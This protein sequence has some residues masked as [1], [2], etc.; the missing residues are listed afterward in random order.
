M[1]ILQETPTDIQGGFN[2]GIEGSAMGLMMDILQRFQY[3]YPI[4]STIRE[5]VSN[6]IDSVTEKN[7]AA[8]ILSGKA[9]ITDYYE[10][11]EG[12]LYNDSKFD[13]SYYDA[14]YFSSNDKVVV[15][16]HCGDNMDKDFVTIEDHGVGLGGHRLSKYFSLG[17]ST[18]RLSKL[19]LG[20]F[21]I[22]AKAP[23]SVNPYYT[24]ESRYNGLRYKFNVYNTKVESVIPKFNLN[25]GVE[26]VP[27]NF[28]TGVIYAEKTTEKNGVIVTMEAKKHH[29]QEYKDAVE[30][31]LMYFTNVDF[32]VKENGQSIRQNFT[33]EILYEDDCLVI[34]DN[35]YFNKPHMLLN[36]VNY[37]FIDFKELELEDMLG[38]VGIKVLPEDVE[39]SPSR[40]SLVWSEKTKAMV[41]QRFKDASESASRIIQKEMQENDFIK[42]LRVCN[43]IKNKWSNSSNIL[44][45]LSNIVNLDKVDINFT[46]DP[47]IKYHTKMLSSFL[48]REVFYSHITKANKSGKK[49]ERLET[50]TTHLNDIVILKSSR[51]SNRKDKYLLSL[52]GRFTTLEKPEWMNSLLIL[53]DLEENKALQKRHDLEDKIYKHLLSSK[54]ILIYEDIEV[55]EDFL[56]SEED[57]DITDLENM[58]AEELA[59][60]NLT[61][62]ERRKLNGSTIVHTPRLK[63]SSLIGHQDRVYEW[64]KVEVPVKEIDTWDEEE[65]Y[66]GTDI[67]A[68]TL[69]FVALL[70]RD[71]RTESI[72]YPRDRQIV[73]YYNYRRD[74]DKDDY[75]DFKGRYNIYSHAEAYRCAHFFDPH[76][77]RI[78]KVA[79]DKVKL[80]QD[81]KHINKFF[82]KVNGHTITMS[83]KLIRWNTSRL[84][85]EQLNKL[86]FLQNFPLDIEQ[87]EKYNTLTKY[88]ITNYVDMK[89]DNV[90]MKNNSQAYTDMLSHLDKVQQFQMLV[91][92]EATAEEI[93]IV[94]KEM[95]GSAEIQDGC[96]VDLDILNILNELLDWSKPVRDL[97]NG[98]EYLL[99]H[100]DYTEAFN[101]YRTPYKWTI[102][103]N[104]EESI[105]RYCQEKNVI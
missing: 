36:K 53:E 79:K 23:L 54:E 72:G 60:I 46:G 52:H 83:N 9:Q 51:A 42:W 75:I 64:Q 6:G 15:T 74:S 27:I 102:P 37:G 17:Y 7:V 39:I 81:F 105:I 43:S 56:A 55:P 103:N 14:T 86:N 22:G 94:A 91:K 97:L 76:G 96:A 85:K 19:P 92:S 32:Y 40:E 95:W 61:N 71:N 88:V 49:V 47:S 57:E 24:M 34:S 8:L 41:L 68:Q 62:E 50:E 21:G 104:M 65:I 48:N 98:I 80:Y 2:K 35:R 82:L 11:I 20:K 26:N 4:K 100:S 99:G 77:I 89:I 67:D 58:T 1:A 63:N 13:P 78:I 70:T 18:K 87:K 29:L 84:V 101:Q 33:P 16:Y 5:L 93:S 25:T 30:R 31:Q 66:Y 45:R 44:G 59:N 73:D 28:E 12:E 38:N 90:A 10:E 3:Q 69:E